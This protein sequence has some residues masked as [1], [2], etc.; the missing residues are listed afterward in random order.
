MKFKITYAIACCLVIVTFFF[1]WAQDRR[2]EPPPPGG[3]Q[4]PV[5]GGPPGFGGPGWGFPGFGPPPFAMN[6]DTVSSLLAIDEVRREIELQ[7]RQKEQLEPIVSK[8]QRILENAMQSTDFASLTEASEEERQR[9]TRKVREAIEIAHRDADAEIVQ[10]LDAAQVERLEQLRVQRLGGRA[11]TEPRIQD[12]LQLSNQ[13]RESLARLVEQD[14]P[15]GGFGFG[16]QGPGG[17]RG[18]RR[19]PQGGTPGDGDPAIEEK[20]LALLTD[21]QREIWNLLVG[22]KFQFPMPPT[23]PGPMGEQRKILAQFDRDTDGILNRD[24]RSKARDW[25]RSQPARGRGPGPGGMPGR[26][27]GGF[28]GP[29]GPGGRGGPGGGFGP[30]GMG[31]P[32]M[33]NSEPAKPGRKVAV[34]DVQTYPQEPLYSK[35]VVRTFFLE[36]EN[37]DWENELADF[38]NT[39]VE[40]PATLIVDG[41]EFPEVGIHFRGMSSFGM[42]PDGY[43]R[44]LNVSLDFIHSDQKLYGRKTLNLLNAHEDPSFLH[45]VLYL[46]AA[47][48]YTLAPVANFVQVVINGESWG[49]YINAEQF[50]KEFIEE[51]FQTSKGARWK[52]PG[53]P[54]GRGGL[55]YL[56]EDI[57]PYRRIFEI[58]SKDSK[59]SWD[60]LVHLCKVLNTTPIQDLPAKIEP[61]L[62]MEGALHFLAL[63]VALINGDGYWTRASDYCLYRDPKGVF[64]LVVHDANETLKP[65]MGPGM[66]GPGGRGGPPGANGRGGRPDQSGP[67][68][69]QLQ[70][71]RGD[72]RPGNGPPD[73]DRP[74]FGPGGGRGFGPPGGPGGRSAVELDPLVA[75]DDPSKPLRSKLLA[76]PQYRKR[77]LEIVKKINEEILGGDY[78]QSRIEHYVPLIS[79]TIK[80]DTRKLDS[81]ESFQAAVATDSI[82]NAPRG[83]DMSLMDFARARYLYLK[84]YTEPTRPR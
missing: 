30:P 9:A 63:D 14:R 21:Q 74:G 17:N 6:A 49:L 52:V 37:E 59:E 28:G 3:F 69:R 56:G 7:P 26:G 62:D 20:S 65:A 60:A 72:G 19:G 11:F 67:G 25:I 73:G 68:D 82:S 46:E 58:K 8:L 29:G 15:R 83:R 76:V 22:K 10:L 42:V 13:Q 78:L 79:E 44:S 34:E 4:P 71:P 53:S 77:Y 2:P 35:S 54:G 50:N 27:P 70:G 66:G 55:E 36:F 18:E 81:F 16:P 33:R 64:H 43:K 47:Q 84:N 75:I 51:R 1:S 38:N 40:V 23:G 31:P 24:E 32:P 61:I 5:F 12:K 45:T 39:D 80:N 48:K 41:K 57:A